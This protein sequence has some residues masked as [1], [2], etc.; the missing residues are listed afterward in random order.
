MKT[1]TSAIAHL[2]A[3]II[4]LQEQ[5]RTLSPQL[6]KVTKD[7]AA[8]GAKPN[9]PIEQ[10]KLPIDESFIEEVKAILDD[11]PMSVRV[12][13]MALG[14]FDLT[15]LKRK[16]RSLLAAGVTNEK[17][18]GSSVQVALTDEFQQAVLDSNRKPEPEEEAK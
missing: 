7:L 14:V 9:D 5:H 10:V 17:A 13:Q 16:R 2:K 1:T 3:H 6:E 4:S 11:K 12:F 8:L 15:E 18:N